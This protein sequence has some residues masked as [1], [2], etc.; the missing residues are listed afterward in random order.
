MK[1]P[2][3]NASLACA[4]VC[5]T[6]SFSATP[7]LATPSIL[8]PDRREMAENDDGDWSGILGV[9]A[10]IGPAYSGSSKSKTDPAAY[11]DIVWRN[12]V[13]LSNGGLGVYFVNNADWQAGVGVGYSPGRKESDSPRE[14]RGLGDQ[15]DAANVQGFVTRRTLGIDLG[16]SATYTDGDFGGTQSTL[17]AAKSFD[18]SDRVM[19]IASVAATYAD[20]DWMNAQYGVTR[21]QANRSG[22]RAFS[23][24]SGFESAEFSL[25]GVYS[26]SEHWFAGA[27]VSTTALLGD[28]ADSP[29]TRKDTQ[30]S[31]L[32]IIGRT[33]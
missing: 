25:I 30:S 6:L 5:A 15:D 27:E 10:G 20:D 17:S 23:A 19:L 32:I 9:G 3:I 13:F 1:N 28:A 21:R 29:I 22:L 24:K 14:L 12:R 26:L 31:G 4:A 8:G 16:V 11:V 33:F 7:A 2:L 18:L